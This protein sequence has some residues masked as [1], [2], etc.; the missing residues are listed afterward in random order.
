[1]QLDSCAHDHLSLYSQQSHLLSL[2][3]LT[4]AAR[5][6][7]AK[8]LLPIAWMTIAASWTT[9]TPSCPGNREGTWIDKLLL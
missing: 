8:Q 1:M 7:P 6:D 5:T 2:L 9:A 3:S 4:V